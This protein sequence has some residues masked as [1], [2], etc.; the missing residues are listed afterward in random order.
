MNLDERRAVAAARLRDL[1]HEFM[2]RGLSDEELEQL[3]G[4]VEELLARVREAPPRV[5][6]VS[7]TAIA[8]FEE[9][10]SR[11]GRTHR[12]QLFVDSPVSGAANPL[13][14]AA[15]LWREGDTAVMEATFGPAFE[16]APGRVHGGMVAALIDE[17]MGLAMGL[18]GNVAFTVQLDISYRAATPLGEPVVVRAR[19]EGREGRKLRLRAL[20][21]TGDTTVAEASAIFVTVDPT[22]FLGHLAEG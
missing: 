2:S 3:T 22:L 1:G 5:R 14:V 15:Y 10:M 8:Q 12:H 21:T 6:T 16:G 20:V 19:V 4:R 18:E 17:A 9:T 11:D 7:E 13:G